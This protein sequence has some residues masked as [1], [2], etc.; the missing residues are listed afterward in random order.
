MMKFQ[1]FILSAF[2]VWTVQGFLWDAAPC[3]I[4]RI[5]DGT[6]QTH[7]QI[8]MNTLKEHTNAY[9]RIEK[10]LSNS[11]RKLAF[12]EQV[13]E[14]FYVEFNE[15][16]AES[17]LNSTKIQDSLYQAA[18]NSTKIQQWQSDLAL[19]TTKMMDTLYNLEASWNAQNAQISHGFT[20]LGVALRVATMGMCVYLYA[21]RNPWMPLA[22]ALSFMAVLVSMGITTRITEWMGT[23]SIPAKGEEAAVGFG[24]NLKISPAWVQV[25]VLAEM[26]VMVMATI[27]AYGFVVFLDKMTGAKEQP[28]PTEKKAKRPRV[29]YITAPG[30][31]QQQPTSDTLPSVYVPTVK[32]EEVDKSPSVY[33]RDLPISR[34]NAHPLSTGRFPSFAQSFGRE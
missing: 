22:H 10:N 8:I 7:F 30:V 16:K 14:K 19:N 29:I 6:N 25:F 1:L 2:L 11:T 12:V 28:K 17:A 9:A 20:Y 15:F 23:P 4:D 18:L 27:G 32:T 31:A 34:P 24:L 26:I 13:V 5:A 33:L 3:S 21:L